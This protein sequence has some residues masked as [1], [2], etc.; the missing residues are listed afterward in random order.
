[1]KCPRCQVESDAGAP[2]CEDCGARLE[3]ACPSCGT[4]VTAGKKFCRSCGAALS[5]EPGGRFASSESYTPTHLAEKILT[6]KSALEGERKQVTVLFADLKGSMELLADRDPEE[7]RKLLDPVIERMMESVHRYEGTVNQVM[8]DGIMALFGAPLAHED[9]AVRACYAALRMQESVKRYAE[10]VQRTE[11]IPIQIRVGLNSGEVVVR[12]IGSDL[13]MDYTAIGQTVHLAARME[14]MASA[15]SILMTADTQRL[16]AGYVAVK[17]LG[18][19]EVKGLKNPVEVF[20]ITGVG[21]VRRSL[22]ASVARGLTRFVG[23]DEEIDQLR[24]ALARATQGHGQVVAAVGEP[25][26]GKS[27]LFHEVTHARRMHGWLVLEGCSVSYGKTAAYLSIIDLLKGYFRIQDRDEPREV[28]EKIASKLLTL[29]RALEPTLQALLA[30]LTVPVEDPHWQELHPLARHERILDAVRRLLLRESQIQPLCL[31]F[32]DL[33]WIDPG[34]QAILDRLVESLPTARLL[35]L[36]NYRPEFQHSWASKTYYTQVR[37][38]PLPPE[39]AKELLEGLLGAD[40][41]LHQLKQLLVEHTEGNPLFLEESVR[42]LVDTHALTGA[43]GVYRLTKP[44][45]TI[46]I[47]TTVQAILAGRIDRLP[48]DEKYLLQSASVFGETVPLILLQAIVE[49]PESS[50]SKGLRHLQTAE[51]LYAASLFPNLEYSFRHG[52]TCQVAYG[53]L[54]QERRKTLH[55]KV[56]AVIEGMYPDRLTEHIE[57]LAHHAIRGETWERAVTYA[58]QAASRAMD[59]SAYAQAGVY[60]DQAL[61]ALTRLPESR[62]TMEQAVDLKFARSSPFIALGELDRHIS[63]SEEA[64]QL[65]KR[66]GDPHR[67]ARITSA[68]GNALWQRGENARA[69]EFVDSVLVVSESLGEPTLVMNAALN[70]GLICAT[71]GDYRRAADL[72]GRAAAILT[73]DRLRQRFGRVNYPAVT[74]RAALAVSLSELGLF[75][76]AATVADECLGIVELLAHQN[77]MLLAYDAACTVLLRRGEFHHSVPRLERA[78][79]LCNEKGFHTLFSET[80]GALGYAYARVG[81]MREA[82]SL[83]E[84]AGEYAPRVARVEVLVAVYLGEAYLLAGR[85]DDAGAVARRTLALARERSERANEARALH[86]LGEVAAHHDPPDVADDTAYR[87]ALA[88]AEELQM[89]PLVAHCHLGLGKLYRRAGRRE[90]AHEHLTTA[91]TLY[92]EMDMRFWL[93]KAETA[94]REFL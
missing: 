7:A 91:T 32:E 35:L 66:L 14:Q 77:G 53:G 21:S 30:L 39:S 38:D 20:E 41:G 62:A 75:A 47:P 2:F 4:P 76:Q 68:V 8:G 49:M 58:R 88:L 43:R 17:S 87:E 33:H 60:F 82:L 56:V 93:E 63:C 90:Q 13:F 27:R 16:A 22:D 79:A 55:A 34:T 72:L 40:S 81:R 48:P 6:S 65:A 51:F 46:Q 52:L 83:L 28:R 50:L 5:T 92:R 67:L 29:D 42:S 44:V 78:L 19:V 25:G 36:V 86:L 15:G 57:R 74:A 85:A 94:M 73:G 89:R 11:G 59:R 84:Q 18:P 37:V 9:H 80:A 45:E 69:R 26:V 24:K 71:N 1:M 10:E 61:E 64:L 12:A 3:A 70:L 23:R 54:L 31:V